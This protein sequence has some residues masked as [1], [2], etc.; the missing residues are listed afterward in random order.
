MSP[1]E[2][3]FNQI[4]DERLKRRACVEILAPL[5]TQGRT[6][7][8]FRSHNGC[9]HCRCGEYPGATLATLHNLTVQ[10]HSMAPCKHC[11]SHTL[12]SY[13]VLGKGMQ[14][15]QRVHEVCLEGCQSPSSAHHVPSRPNLASTI[16]LEREQ[17][18]V[19][20]RSLLHHSQIGS[21]DLY[22]FLWEEGLET[23]SSLAC[24]NHKFQQ[25]SIACHLNRQAKGSTASTCIP[26]ERENIKTCAEQ[27]T[28]W[29][30]QSMQET[31]RELECQAWSASAASVL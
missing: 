5:W 28:C 22:I 4:H 2:S 25:I 27:I 18:A 19:L 17:F 29:R 6:T 15:G 13:S 16:Q 24:V 20:T 1:F 3:N 21:V 23:A 26:A 12:F 14:G 9:C 8:H 11:F 10:I 7:C 31:I 30:F